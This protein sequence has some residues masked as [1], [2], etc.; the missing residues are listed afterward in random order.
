MDGTR[1]KEL[2]DQFNVGGWPHLLM[3]RKVKP[4]FLKIYTLLL[5]SSSLVRYRPARLDLHESASLESPLKGHQPL[6]VFNFKNKK[7]K[8]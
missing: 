4:F 2:A 7:L 1:E 6:Y 3:F 5:F 8:T